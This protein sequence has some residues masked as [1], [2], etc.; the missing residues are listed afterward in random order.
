[1]TLLGP[2]TLF[3]IGYFGTWILRLAAR[4]CLA[5]TKRRVNKAEL[6]HYPLPPPRQPNYWEET[7][8]RRTLH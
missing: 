3:A 2:L 7:R 8:E 4:K 1:M 5:W 6:P